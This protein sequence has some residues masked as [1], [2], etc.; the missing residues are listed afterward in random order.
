MANYYTT[1]LINA[2]TGEVIESRKTKHRSIG[3]A[4]AST[5]YYERRRFLSGLGREHASYHAQVVVFDAQG[6]EALRLVK[7]EVRTI[8]RVV[9]YM[10]DFEVAVMAEALTGRHL[11]WF[12][13]KKEMAEELAQVTW[14]TGLGAQ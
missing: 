9:S 2:C 11:E 4:V 14:E 5:K 7:L 13:I 3:A 10:P 1:A 8:Q 6:A 12:E